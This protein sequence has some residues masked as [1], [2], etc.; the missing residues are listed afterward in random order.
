MEIKDYEKELRR[1]RKSRNVYFAVVVI[2]IGIVAV[3]Q[4]SY[5]WHQSSNLAASYNSLMDHYNNLLGKTNYL[6]GSLSGLQKEMEQMLQT[7]DQK[8]YVYNPPTANTTVSI[9]GR[10]QTITPHGSIEW[11]LLDTFVN[12]IDISSNVTAIYVIVDPANFV[13]LY[14]NKTYTSLVEY[15]GTHFVRTERLSQGCSGYILVIIDRTSH[16]ILLTPNV[17][18]TYAPTSFLTGTCSLAP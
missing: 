12:H 17:T 6:N 10:Q 5:D 16:P 15:T 14:Q 11:S 8:S 4:I 7:Y 9:W 3:G 2:I 18:A 13:Q 1:V